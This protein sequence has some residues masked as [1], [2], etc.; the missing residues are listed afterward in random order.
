M[1]MRAISTTRSPCYKLYARQYI[2]R[3]RP[4]GRREISFYQR[5]E[6]RGHSLTRVLCILGVVCILAS[7]PTPSPVAVA[8]PTGLLLIHWSERRLSSEYRACLAYL[9][10]AADARPPSQPDE[11][12]PLGTTRPSRSRVS[13]TEVDYRRLHRGAPAKEEA[14]K[15]T[16]A[17][18]S[19]T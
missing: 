5:F 10:I 6:F 8:L 16:T 19:A 17:R 13:R 1:T 7:L 15:Q 14:S 9:S 2:R 4:V 11:D 18:S 3:G 12:A